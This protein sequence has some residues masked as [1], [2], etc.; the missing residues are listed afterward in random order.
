MRVSSFSIHTTTALTFKTKV[1]RLAC[2]E[3]RVTE[4]SFAATLRA[5][6]ALP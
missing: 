4:T 5:N 1:L 6:A 3:G 2:I